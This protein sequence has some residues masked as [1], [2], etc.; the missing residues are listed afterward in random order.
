[1]IVKESKL[2]SKF[3]FRFDGQR[4]RS[5]GFLM[6]ITDIYATAVDYSLD[7]RIIKFF[8][9]RA[10]KIRYAVHGNTA[11]EVIMIRAEHTKEHIQYHNLYKGTAF[12]FLVDKQPLRN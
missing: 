5:D 6:W 3:A 9:S 2:A 7:S 4:K 10:E 12:Q 1:M 8:C 11:A